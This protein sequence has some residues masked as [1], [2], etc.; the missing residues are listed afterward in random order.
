MNQ[1]VFGYGSL[2]NPRSRQKTIPGALAT[3]E[4]T[5][6]GY[7]RKFNIPVD[8]YLYVNIVPDMSGSVEGVCIQVSEDELNRLKQRERGYACIDVTENITGDVTGRVYAFIAPDKNF[9]KMKILQS[10]IDTC[11]IG[12]PEE[13]RR[14]WLEETIIENKIEDDRDNPKYANVAASLETSFRNEQK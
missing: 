14:Q 6:R 2:M 8:G 4:A 3:T 5:L 7:R 11:L 10:Y 1:Y 9:P 12:I 13:K